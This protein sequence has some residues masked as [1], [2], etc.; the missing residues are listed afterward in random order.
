V[1]CWF[2]ISSTLDDKIKKERKE[3]ERKFLKKQ[4]HK[5]N[6]LIILFDDYAFV[7]LSDEI[8]ENFY[9]LFTASS[10]SFRI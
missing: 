5:N 3:I 6:T 9:D 2:F 8:K 1:G 10:G 4:K 7:T